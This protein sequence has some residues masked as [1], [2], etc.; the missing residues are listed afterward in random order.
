MTEP[1]EFVYL[2]IGGVL[3]N[4]RDSYQQLAARLNLTEEDIR[5]AVQEYDDDVCRG[6]TP[7]TAIWENILKKSRVEDHSLTTFEAFRQEFFFPLPESH[8][9]ARR[10]S[11]G[12]RIGI[13]SNL[14]RGDFDRFL[15]AGIV[16]RLDYSAVV[17]S[18][19]IGLIKPETGIFEY[20]TW[21]AGVPPGRILFVDDTQ[22]H[23]DAAS[24]YG[25]QTIGF[26]DSCSAE[27][28]RAVERKLGLV[29]HPRP[30]TNI[31]RMHEL[32]RRGGP[33]SS[34]WWMACQR[35][36]KRSCAPMSVPK[37]KSPTFAQWSHLRHNGL[38]SQSA[39]E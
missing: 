17:I 2:D 19:E 32:N 36:K 25:W 30:S 12:Y 39:E 20:A 23:R 37:L 27:S 14:Y 16:P 11:Q 8:D 35:Y 13:L 4:W 10:L 34:H 38:V 31:S 28:V 22:R 1:I 3:M 18:S 15:R 5:S 33:C 29:G 7:D 26:D 24:A 6:L 9:L 21:K